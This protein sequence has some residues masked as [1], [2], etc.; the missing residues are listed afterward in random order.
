MITATSTLNSQEVEGNGKSA[1]A[2]FSSANYPE[3]SMPLADRV[4][5][6]FYGIYIGNMQAGIE[7]IETPTK[8]A[9]QFAV[10]Q[11]YLLIKILAHGLTLVTQEPQRSSYRESQFRLSATLHTS[12]RHCNFAESNMYATRYLFC[13]STDRI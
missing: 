8:L 1:A 9:N 7:L 6:S 3:T 2:L 4:N 11:S 5:A 12:W 10:A 13:Q